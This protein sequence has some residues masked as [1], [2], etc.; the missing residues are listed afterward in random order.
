[1]LSFEP[2]GLD[3]DEDVSS[4]LICRSNSADSI[5]N[6]LTALKT[7]T[8]NDKLHKKP[9]KSS[10]EKCAKFAANHDEVVF[11][12][13]VKATSAPKFEKPSTKQSNHTNASGT[14]SEDKFGSGSSRTKRLRASVDPS[15]IKEIQQ[16]SLRKAIGIVPQDTVLFNDSI[17]R[18]IK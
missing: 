1:M 17:N 9:A 5:P 11:I 4:L 13:E 8:N 16:A 10:T 2:L 15:T 18:I 3:D 14:S 12:S 6:D 7:A